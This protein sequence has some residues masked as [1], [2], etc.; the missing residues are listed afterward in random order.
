MAVVLMSTHDIVVA[1]FL[2]EAN[3]MLLPFQSML[4]QEA[5]VAADAV[6]CSRCCFS[7]WGAA[8]APSAACCWWGCA[9]GL[10]ISVGM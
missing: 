9:D 2:V 3:E 6:P 1:W 10:N 5:A 4:F 8:S 7:L